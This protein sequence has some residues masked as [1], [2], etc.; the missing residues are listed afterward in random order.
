MSAP[1][2]PALAANRDLWDDWARRNDEHVA[3]HTRALLSGRSTL[4]DYELEE[5]GDV[6]GKSLL[7]LQCHLGTDTI[8]WSRLGARATGVDYSLE[9]ITIARRIAAEVGT[10]TRFLYTDVYHLPERTNQRF[11]IVYASRGVLS[12]LP[13]LD[14]WAKVVAQL[15]APGG[16]FYLTDVHPVFTALREESA[17]PRIGHPYFARPEP[18]TVPAR[19][20]APESADGPA[21]P[22]QHLWPHS[23]GEV[24]TA[25]CQAGLTLSFY[26]E[27]P[28]V[29]RGRPFLRKRDEGTWTL[30]DGE[31]PLYFSLKAVLA[32]GAR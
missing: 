3:R 24:I 7:H 16:V 5:L 19:L 17:E 29:D 8:G 28:W 11:A 26:H 4:R 10:D 18:V 23:M 6:T 14:A 22:L 21:A 20:T 32:P 30:K 1:W 15:L 27:F 31:L 2:G 9:S 13:D 25:L 12:W